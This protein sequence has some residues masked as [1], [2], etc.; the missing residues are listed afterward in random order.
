MAETGG[1]LMAFFK[2]FFVLTA[3]IGGLTIL[4]LVNYM[5]H[6]I[7]EKHPN[8]DSIQRTN[9]D[10]IRGMTDEELAYFMANIEPCRESAWIDWLKQEV[11]T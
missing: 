11:E 10:I 7:L 3:C 8:K 1:E 5:V 2:L 9:A 4:V 6:I